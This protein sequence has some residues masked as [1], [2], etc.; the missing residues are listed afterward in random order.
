M[1]SM[2]ARSPL[3]KLGANKSLSVW[4]LD[5]EPAACELGEPTV[6]LPFVLCNL[7][8]FTV[9]GLASAAALAASAAS[10]A[11]SAAAFA[12]LTSSFA[13]FNL[14]FKPL[15][16]PWRRMMFLS[17][18]LQSAFLIVGFC[19]SAFSVT[20]AFGFTGLFTTG[21]ARSSSYNLLI[22]AALLASF[23][24]FLAASAALAAAAA[25]FFSRASYFAW[26]L[27]S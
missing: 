13:I 22:S 18:L 12:S 3:K 14:S 9:V 5:C 6:W 25:A 10:L 23:N 19:S 16:I 20:I 24:A 11:S 26:S 2:L 1:P 27:A 17:Y 21:L 7:P 15:I 8:G 4:L